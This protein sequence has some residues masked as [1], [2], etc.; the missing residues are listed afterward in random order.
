ML[1]VYYTIDTEFWTTRDWNSPKDYEQDFERDID[2]RTSRG[3]FGLDFQLR[4]FTELGLKA[5]CFVETTHSLILG[6]EPL[7]RMVNIVNSHGHDV[8]LHC[9]TEWLSTKVPWELPTLPTPLTG[10]KGLHMRHFS[11]SSQSAIIAEGIAA[12]QHC[13]TPEIYAFR[14]GNYGANMA[15]LRAL[16]S[17]G[18]L[19]DSSYN[20]PYLKTA[21][22]IE[23]PEPLLSPKKIE[24]VW[25]IPIPY[26]DTFRGHRHVQVAAASNGELEAALMHAYK[27][28]W[29]SFVIVSHSFE[30]VHRNRGD[31]ALYNGIQ[32]R[33]FE[34]LCQFLKSHPDKFRTRTFSELASDENWS[35]SL[36]D[37]STKY[38][39]HV[40]SSIL[41]VGRLVEQARQRWGW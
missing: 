40:M 11:E 17:N 3:S 5:V 19:Y 22:Q 33:R 16:S 28:Q 8:Q 30:L 14:A 7:E 24:G 23:T 41:T 34:K 37:D 39:S 31:A 12:L 21:C 18:I 36:D 6:I 15:T 25:E 35:D 13:G 20:Y 26:F 2:G 27:A 9:H 1:D 32:V 10:K 4:R 29:K 38:E